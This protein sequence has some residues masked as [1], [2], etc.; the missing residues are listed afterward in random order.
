MISAYPIVQGYKDTA[1]VGMRAEFA[2]RLRLAGVN[3]DASY[4]PDP[5][6]A[7]RTSARTFHSTRIMWDWKLTGYYN[8]ADFYDLFGPTKLSRKG[9]SLKLA[10]SQY[11]ILRYAAHALARL[12]RGRLLRSQRAAGVSE[13]FHQ[14]H[15]KSAGREPGAEV[16]ESA[17]GAGRGG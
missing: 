15:R 11:L 3:V 5:S 8:Y 9:E 1:G 13:C 2:D 7:A 12:E 14:Q 16:F 17:P 4:S 6:L 10:H